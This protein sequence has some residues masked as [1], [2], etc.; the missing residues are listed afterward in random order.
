MMLL[1]DY[2]ARTGIS[3]SEAF[4]PVKTSDALVVQYRQWLDIA[5]KGMPWH[6][7]G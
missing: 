3:L 4:L 5:G 6:K 7:A 2:V 1:Q